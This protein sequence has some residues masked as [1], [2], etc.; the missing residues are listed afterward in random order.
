M[1]DRHVSV[2]FYFPDNIRESALG[3]LGYIIAVPKNPDEVEILRNITEP[4]TFIRKMIGKGWNCIPFYGVNTRMLVELYRLSPYP[5]P[6]DINIF[7]Y[8]RGIVDNALTLLLKENERR[9]IP[10]RMLETQTDCK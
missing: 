7:N 6:K 9:D 8:N 3:N 5:R 4:D 2:H 10:K 1:E